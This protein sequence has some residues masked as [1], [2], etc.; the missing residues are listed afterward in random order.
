MERISGSEWMDGWMLTAV[1]DEESILEGTT[2]TLSYTYSQDADLNDHFFWYQQYPGKPP[3]FLIHIS[4]MNISRP[5]EFLKSA[6]RF[7][8]KLSGKKRLD[9][10]ISSAA[11]TD[12]AVYYCAVRP[13]VTGNTKTLGTVTACLYYFVSIS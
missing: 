4:G 8:T 6:A 9:L 13:T 12:S 3:E 5:S 2:L 7:S 11:V 10:Q 1:K